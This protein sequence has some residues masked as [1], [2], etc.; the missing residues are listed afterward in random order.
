MNTRP[1]LGQYRHG[2]TRSRCMQRSVR[3]LQPAARLGFTPKYRRGPFTSAILDRCEQ[4]MADLCADFGA[5]P[6]EFNGETDHVHRLVHYH[7]RSRCHVWSLASKG[8]SAGRLRQVF[9][10]HI[11]KYLCGEHF[12]SPSSSQA[13]HYPSSRTHPR[14]ETPYLNSAPTLRATTGLRFLPA[15]KGR[16][17]SQEPA[18]R[19]LPS[20]CWQP[21]RHLTLPQ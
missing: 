1:R 4:I 8:V 5:Q 20:E 3:H 21:F 13:H 7:P 6:R 17:S 9:V 14:P 18:E 2:G 11:R 16:G 15:V 12:W 10:G 19:Q